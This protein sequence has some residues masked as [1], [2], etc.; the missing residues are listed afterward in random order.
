MKYVVYL[1]KMKK[2]EKITYKNKLAYK[3]ITKLSSQQISL[4]N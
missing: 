2:Y 1:F 3:I 4:F